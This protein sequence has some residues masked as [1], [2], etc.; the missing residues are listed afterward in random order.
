VGGKSHAKFFS[1]GIVAKRG[2]VV[3]IRTGSGCVSPLPPLAMAN[4]DDPGP[5]G[6]GSGSNATD[7]RPAAPQRIRQRSAQH[8]Q[9]L[10]VGAA[11]PASSRWTDVRLTL[12]L[13]ASLHSARRSQKMHADPWPDSSPRDSGAGGQVRFG[14]S[15]VRP[16]QA[17]ACPAPK[18]H[19]SEHLVC[20]APQALQKVPTTTVDGDRV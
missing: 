15:D 18:A 10:S 17:R 19:H 5:A 2:G 12:D 11:L 14:R 7:W 4:N 9:R 6:Y 8:E 20:Y 13:S 16:S 1:V 3:P